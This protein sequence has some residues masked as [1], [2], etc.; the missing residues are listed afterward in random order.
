MDTIRGRVRKFG[1]NVDT[2]IITP[3]AFLHLSLAE[4]KEHAFEPVFPAFSKTVQE[5][6]IIVAGSNFG[7]GSSREHATQVVKDM[8]I[9]YIACESMARIYMRNC[10]ALGI[11]PILAKGVSAL[12]DEGD[13]I[14]IDFEQAQAR[15]PKT[16]ESVSFKPLKGTP[17]EI[18]DGG[19]I[20][21]LL[22]KIV[23][24]GG[25]ARSM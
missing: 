12:F 24:Q 18:F 9:R 11:Y 6:D 8:G 1:D 19:G 15:N 25:R 7:C 5:G 2:D 14:E 23:A 21:P 16:G 3:A 17:K 4:I 10:V 20:L 22:K 13:A